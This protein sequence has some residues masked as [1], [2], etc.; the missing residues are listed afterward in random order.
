MFF[1]IIFK[2]RLISGNW[3]SVCSSSE[4]VF[5]KRSVGHPIRVSVFPHCAGNS[6]EDFGWIPYIM[7]NIHSVFLL[8]P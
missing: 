5:P 3:F 1:C 2:G 7:R 4:K 6:G 8:L